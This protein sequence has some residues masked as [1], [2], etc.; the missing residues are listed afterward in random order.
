MARKQLEI[1]GT[2]APKIAAVDTAAEAYVQARDKRMKLSE[3]EKIAKDALIAVM[4][5]HKLTVYRDT[6]ATPPLFVT[7]STKDN[8]QVEIDGPKDT[9][10]SD[11]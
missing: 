7:V 11:E 6:T 9:D 4:R 2:E 3:K 8:V 5:E 10:E 1:A